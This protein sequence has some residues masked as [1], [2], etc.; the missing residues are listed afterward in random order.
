M[1]H[2]CMWRS[3][4]SLGEPVLSIYMCFAVLRTKRCYPL[5]ISLILLVQFLSLACFCCGHVSQPVLPEIQ[6]WTG[7]NVHARGQQSVCQHVSGVWLSGSG[8]ATV[9]EGIPESENKVLETGRW[10]R[11][12]EGLEGKPGP[13][14]KHHSPGLSLF[15]VSWARAAVQPPP[16]ILPVC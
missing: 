6:K 1:C 3:E 15:E 5:A 8:E 12:V 14:G 7:Q 9:R 13:R 11:Q 16:F 2:V 4:D 10:K